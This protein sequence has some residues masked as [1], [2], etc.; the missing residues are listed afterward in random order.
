MSAQ[1]QRALSVWLGVVPFFAFAL[2]FLILPTLHVML[3]A[4]QTPEGAF[5]LANLGGLMTGSILKAG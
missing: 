2:V 4:F 1:P 5:T 3:G